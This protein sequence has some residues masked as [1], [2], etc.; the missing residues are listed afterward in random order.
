MTAKDKE[1]TNSL[2]R[3]WEDML[4]EIEKASDEEI[5]EAAKDDDVLPS[6]AAA[7]VREA[8]LQSVRDFEVQQSVKDTSRDMSHG[9]FDLETKQND[10]RVDKGFKETSASQSKSSLDYQPEGAGFAFFLSD[11][12]SHS[13]LLQLLRLNVA[14]GEQ[15]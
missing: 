8:L 6:D 15:R 10:V 4:D 1:A 11:A 13:H 14:D 2:M 5:L 9:T 3:L 7:E 12:E